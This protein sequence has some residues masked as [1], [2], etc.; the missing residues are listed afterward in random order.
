MFDSITPERMDMAKR[1]LCPANNLTWSQLAG[2]DSKRWWRHSTMAHTR[3]HLISDCLTEI[4]LR[5]PLCLTF[6]Q[7]IFW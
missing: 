1:R 4:S 2:L 7:N 3:K 6:E 5:N